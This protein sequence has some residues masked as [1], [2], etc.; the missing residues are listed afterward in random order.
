MYYLWFINFIKGFLYILIQSSNWKIKNL[1]E[2]LV[3]YKLKKIVARVESVEKILYFQKN[4]VGDYLIK[5]R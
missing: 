3:E 1:I 4:K 5:R 2:Y